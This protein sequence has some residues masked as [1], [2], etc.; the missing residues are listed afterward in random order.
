MHN[1]RG[2]PLKKLTEQKGF[3]LIEMLIVL[4]IVM[5]ISL[6]CIKVSMKVSEK[7]VVDHFFNQLLL[8][9]QTTQQLAKEKERICILSFSSLNR[10]RV[11]HQLDEILLEREIPPCI[12][13]EIESNLKSI[14]FNPNGSIRKFGT[15]KFYT[16]YGE[17]YVVLNIQKGRIRYVE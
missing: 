14:Q 13:F 8:D 9:I 15:L 6:I 12:K 5:T 7:I 16:P 11:Y 2:I 17:R 1:K 3:T 10:Y 4:S